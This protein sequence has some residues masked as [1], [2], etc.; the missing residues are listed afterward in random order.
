MLGV[1]ALATRGPT[2]ATAFTLRP[3]DCFDLPDD[4]RVGDIALRDC[5]APHDAEAF[6]AGDLP[7][8]AA[9]GSSA[10]PG[11]YPGQDAVAAWVSANCGD[12]AQA[13]HTGATSRADLSVGYFYPDAA[14]WGRGERQV[15]C[16]LHARDGSRL[17]APLQDPTASAPASA[18]GRPDPNGPTRA[19]AP[20]GARAPAPAS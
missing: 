10:I 19:S 20:L 2:P 13:S 3:G 17:S 14:A 5:D 8:G 11:P 4:A 1:A 7:D 18:A 15:T 6:V 9:A 12:A 16:Y